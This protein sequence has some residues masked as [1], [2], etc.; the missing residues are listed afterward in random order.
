MPYDHEQQERRTVEAAMRLKE[1]K[2]SLDKVIGGDTSNIIAGLLA[3]NQ[4]RLSYQPI[5]DGDEENI[6][7]YWDL[8]GLGSVH[9]QQHPWGNRERAAPSDIDD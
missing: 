4:L 8:F 1:V 6:L 7:L 3:S 2:E 5:I 9:K